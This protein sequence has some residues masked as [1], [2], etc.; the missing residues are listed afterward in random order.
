MLY[1][2]VYYLLTETKEKTVDRKK[3][4]DFKNLVKLRLYYIKLYYKKLIKF[5]K[6]DTMSYPKFQF[7]I[8]K[9]KLK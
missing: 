9:E 1:D 3:L 6:L 4:K 2:V 7:L 8:K 5:H